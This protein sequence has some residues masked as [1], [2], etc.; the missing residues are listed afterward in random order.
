MRRFKLA[1]LSSRAIVSMLEGN[2]LQA[3]AIAVV[4]SVGVPEGARV[5]SVFAASER[6]AIA[7]VL[8]HPDF[9]DIP[10]GEEIPLLHALLETKITFVRIHK[11]E[12][13]N[14]V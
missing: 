7:V 8:E 12:A 10:E 6:C 1:Y 14:K 5:I 4:E 3:D 9:A 11:D 2:A 13:A